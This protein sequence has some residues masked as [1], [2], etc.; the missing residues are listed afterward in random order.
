MVA[1]DQ[2]GS[3]FLGGSWRRPALAFAFFFSITMDN[4]G[5][6]TDNTLLSVY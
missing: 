3:V 4:G 1:S 5:E 2:E 6:T